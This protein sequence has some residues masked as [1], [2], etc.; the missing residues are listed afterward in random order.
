[1][2]TAG[3][4]S[5][6]GLTAHV[7]VEH[8]VRRKRIELADEIQPATKVYLDTKYWVIL[9]DRLLGRSCNPHVD[10]L[11]KVLRQ[12]VA[13]RRAICPIS[14]ATFVE[15]FSQTD[16]ATFQATVELI[17]ELSR[18]ISLIE[19]DERF[20]LE[21]F[22]FV[23]QKSQP[24]E[25]LLPL[26]MLVWT[27]VAYTLGFVT[28]VSSVLPADV[29]LALQKEFIDH[30]WTLGLT[31]MVREMGEDAIRS[32]PRD[33]P[34]Q[35][36]DLNDGKFA[37]LDEHNTFKQMFLS[38]IA[39]GLDVFKPDIADLLRHIYECDVGPATQDHTE[40]DDGAR[41]L[42]NLIYHA[43]RLEKVTVELPSMRIAPA[44]MRLSAGTGSASTSATISMTSITP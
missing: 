3:A 33:L 28:P 36:K 27:K 40:F 39:G 23:T 20:R 2:T 38:E 6:K 12:L 10:A 17:D 18:G 7:S 43:F 29:D 11:L 41:R 4:I 42:A 8:H 13:E 30:L 9:R 1:M 34:D 26:Q 25:R 44:C 19:E 24:A 5:Q 22:H 16:R 32:F 31:Q 15:V 14:A 21:F 35:S 37:H